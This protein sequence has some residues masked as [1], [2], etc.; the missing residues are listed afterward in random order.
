LTGLL[1][2]IPGEVIGM[3]AF[4]ALIVALPY[5]VIQSIFIIAISGYIS[6]RHPAYYIACGVF[7]GVVAVYTLFKAQI[8]GELSLQ[9]VAHPGGSRVVS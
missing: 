8:P 3:S 1:Y 5:T 4:I 7:I 9:M 6:L 2:G